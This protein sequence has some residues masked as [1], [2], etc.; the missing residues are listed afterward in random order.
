MT[1]LKKQIAALQNLLFLKI[2]KNL[3]IYLNLINWLWQYISYYIQ[4]IEL[5]QNKKTA[6]LYEDSTVE[7]TRKNYLK[8]TSILNVNQQMCYYQ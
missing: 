2:L 4:Q 1:F 5:L 8:K 6:L 3:E 7:Q